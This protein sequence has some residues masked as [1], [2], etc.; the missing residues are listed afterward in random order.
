MNKKFALVFVLLASL[1]LGLASCTKYSFMSYRKKIIGTWS[2]EKVTHKA[3]LFKQSVD[4]TR[5]YDNWTYEFRSDNRVIARNSATGEEET[6]SWRIDEYT[7]YYYDEDG[8]TSTST[9]YVLR[10]DLNSRTR[11]IDYVW[12]IGS[13]TSRYLRASEYIG[14]ERWNYRLSRND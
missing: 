10:F 9:D 12:N 14:N 1:V 3:G 11:S 7:D 5:N 8:T 2:F 6:G 4:I 13:I